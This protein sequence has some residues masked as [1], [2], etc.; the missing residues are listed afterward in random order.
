MM[1]SICVF[2]RSL[3]WLFREW[4]AVEQE[5]RQGGHLEGRMDSDTTLQDI[6]ILIPRTCECVRLCG[7]GDI[8]G[9]KEWQVSFLF[10]KRADLKIR[11]LSWT[12]WKTQYNQ[13]NPL[14]GKREA[15]GAE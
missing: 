9:T 11:S 3:Y 13:K 6:Y 8:G 5:W 14:N 1:L 4:T 12:I 10:C 7:K 15:E 2:K